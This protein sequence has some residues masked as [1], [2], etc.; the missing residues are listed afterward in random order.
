MIIAPCNLKSFAP[1]YVEHLDPLEDAV[2]G[3]KKRQHAVRKALVD[4]I[5]SDGRVQPRYN[6]IRNSL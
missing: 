5:K 6:I 4:L 3:N 1:S 2:E